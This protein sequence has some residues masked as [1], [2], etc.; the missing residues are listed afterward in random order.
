M[1][2]HLLLLTLSLS[3]MITLKA[4][5]SSDPSLNNAIA[6]LP[7]EEAIP[8]VAIAPSGITY[9]SWFSI[10]N[11]N[12]CIR[13]Q[14]LDSFGNELWADGGLLISDHP[15]MT[16]LTDWDMTVDQQEHAILTWQDI[17]TGANDIF[18]YRISPDG[19]F[20]WGEDGLQLSA[21]DA[22]DVSPKVTVTN[23][24]NAVIAWQSEEGIIRQKISPEGTL[25]WGDAGITMSGAN[26]FTWPQLMPVGDDDVI[27]KFF[28]DTPPT[29]SPTRHVFAQRFD[30]NGSAVWTQNAIISDAGGISAWTQIFP[31]INDGNDGFFIAWHDDRDNNTL[32]NM[33][34]QHVGNDGSVLFADDGVEVSTMPNRHHFYAQLA[35]PEGSEDIFIF[36]N[37]MDANQNDRGIYGQKVSS[38]GTRMWT[39]NGK[40]FIEIS[41]LNVYPLSASSAGQDMVVF[42]EEYFNG[43]EGK[44]KAMRLDAEG[45]YVWTPNMIDLCTVQ[46]E[47]VHTVVSNMNNGQWIAAW[48]DSRN[49]GKDIYGQNIK[50]EGTLGPIQVIY[51]LTGIPDTIFFDYDNNV[52]YQF[53]YAKNSNSE[54]VTIEYITNMGQMPWVLNPWVPLP[55]ILQ[56]NDSVKI[57]INI[58]WSEMA[59]TWNYDYDSINIITDYDYYTV[60]IA[61][62]VG[63]IG[64]N[65]KKSNEKNL[66]ICPNPF[67]QFLSFEFNCENESIAEISIFDNQGGTDMTTGNF[68]CTAGKN[69]YQWNGKTNSGQVVPAGI[70]TYQLK[71]NNQ[72]FSGRLVK[73]R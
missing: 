48:E 9:V 44:L 14:K 68:K 61:I 56:P 18:A 26:A 31:F 2:T 23:A 11:S 42:Y 21:G 36:W 16:W 50:L 45:S 58:I 3:F 37:E 65:E 70:Y 67:T 62:Q 20:V 51:N 46:S 10:E 19:V 4:Q 17:R 15:S 64:T 7:G 22:F 6:D 60:V 30:A 1:K 12:Y 52:G 28:E 47:K 35:L 13:L 5:W 32:A 59:T 29:W 43:I 55:Y 73:I 40:K 72:I 66:K 39:D 57:G 63:F 34:V 27:M 8:K 25:L 24:G 71:L 38:D 41:S 49:G 69:T 54:P 53:F 33:W